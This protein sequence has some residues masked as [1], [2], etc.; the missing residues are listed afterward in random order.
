MI[1]TLY[2]NTHTHIN[3]VLV[4]TLSARVRLYQACMSFHSGKH[5]QLHMLANICPSEKVLIHVQC[6]IQELHVT[7]QLFLVYFY[8]RNQTGIKHWKLSCKEG[9]FFWGNSPAFKTLDSFVQVS[10]QLASPYP[11]SVLI[12]II[13][14]LFYSIL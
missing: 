13:L 7:L 12:R 10:P 4:H 14:L 8:Q 9:Q 1:Y 6:I 2:A 5:L 11:L 3:P